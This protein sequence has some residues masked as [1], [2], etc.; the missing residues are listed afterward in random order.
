MDLVAIHSAESSGLGCLIA[1]TE[2]VEIADHPLFPYACGSDEQLDG[3]A[4]S[5]WRRFFEQ[6]PRATWVERLP[7]T[8]SL[9]RSVD[10]PK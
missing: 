8:T 7:S 6:V 10:F 5:C 2:R 9:R 4:P 3:I 1:A